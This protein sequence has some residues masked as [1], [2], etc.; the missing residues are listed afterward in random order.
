MKRGLLISAVL[1][2]CLGLGFLLIL[3]PKVEEST[4]LVESP[5]MQ[6]A[7]VGNNATVKPV[8]S[9][10]SVLDGT[11]SDEQPDQAALQDG[12]LP[13]IPKPSE[14]GYIHIEWD[15]LMPSNFGAA[16][17]PTRPYSSGPIEHSG[18][19]PSALPTYSSVV[20]VEELIGKKVSIPGFV[21]PLDWDKQTISKFLFVPYVGACVHVPPPPPNQLIYAEFEQGLV[22]EEQ[23]TPVEIYGTLSGEYL[24][25]ELGAAGYTIQVDTVKAFDY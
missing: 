6:R 4:A 7:P 22:L 10:V 9:T 12:F 14:D 17:P 18:S 16:P 3:S 19:G 2:I 8:I 20:L 5:Q 13:L 1:A 15:S 24:E 25:T 11:T 23:W 21:V